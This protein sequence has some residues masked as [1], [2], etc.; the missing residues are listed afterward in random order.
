[1]KY[2]ATIILIICAPWVYGQRTMLTDKMKVT[3]SIQLDTVLIN[4]F[5][6]DT[7]LGGGS[8][9]DLVLPTQKAVKEY[10]DN[11]A[12]MGAGD[13]LGDHT[14]TEDLDMDGNAISGVTG[15]ATVPAIELLGVQKMGM[16]ELTS[17]TSLNGTY[18]TI[19]VDATSGAV[20]LT[21]PAHTGR[22]GW[23][24]TIVRTDDTAN[25]VIIT[26]GGAFEA[27]MFGQDNKAIFRARASG[28]S[29][30]F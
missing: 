9:S 3:T 27:L 15:S 28:W 19:F 8:A 25:A 21:L 7:T 1:M 20:T 26:N 30:T 5:S 4:E 18:N 22:T 14:A 6:P 24:Y 13:D 17:N 10:V 12:V 29:V 2:L 11:N 16:S 23:T